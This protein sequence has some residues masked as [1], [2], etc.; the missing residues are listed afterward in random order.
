VGVACG[1]GAASWPLILIASAPELRAQITQNIYRHS[2]SLEQPA[3]IR[4]PHSGSFRPS[5]IVAN[6]KFPA[7]LLWHP[8]PSLL[9]R[10]FSVTAIIGLGCDAARNHSS[11]FLAVSTIAVIRY[12]G[13][14]GFFQ[15]IE[16]PEVP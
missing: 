5:Q 6:M 4:F 1:K 10:N 2:R 12:N 11:Y 15:L 13:K 16:A 14:T 8:R 3:T 9:Q 7:W